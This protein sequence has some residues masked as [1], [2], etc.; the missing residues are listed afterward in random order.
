LL[1]KV[2]FDFVFQFVTRVIGAQYNSHADILRRQERHVSRNRAMFL[3][4]LSVTCLRPL[5]IG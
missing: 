4:G 3:H 5:F 1:L 2:E